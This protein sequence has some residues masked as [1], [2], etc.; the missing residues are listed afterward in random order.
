M[1]FFLIE[2]TTSF[3]LLI[4]LFH[5]IRYNYDLEKTELQSKYS[6]HVGSCRKIEFDE[7]GELLYSISDDKSINIAET[8]G[9]KAVNVYDNAHE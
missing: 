8:N 3:G 9:G 4:H 7:S 5:S 2:F 6:A 1:K